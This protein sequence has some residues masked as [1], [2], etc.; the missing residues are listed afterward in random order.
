MILQDAELAGVRVLVER[1]GDRYRV[2]TPYDMLLVTD[3]E[4]ARFAMAILREV[5]VAREDGVSAPVSRK[6]SE[7]E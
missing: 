6:W 3:E 2:F 1:A 4:L 5:G 7:A